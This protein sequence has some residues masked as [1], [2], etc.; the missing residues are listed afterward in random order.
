MNA[1]LAQPLQELHDFAAHLATSG[2]SEH[3]ISQSLVTRGMGPGMAY[4]LAKQVMRE[5][6]AQGRHVAAKRICMG[7]VACLL[8]CAATVAHQEFNAG[9]SMALLA[10]AAAMMGLLE[11]GTGL[12]MMIRTD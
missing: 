10:T 12:W 8:S 9:T 5:R 1:L 6:S 2:Y 4:S 11:L 7:A 3:Q